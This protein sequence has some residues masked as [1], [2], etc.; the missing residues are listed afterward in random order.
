MA[1]AHH[2]YFCGVCGQVL[3]DV[4]VPISIGG[5]AGAPWH[6]DEWMTWLPGTTAMDIGGVKTSGFKGFTTT[7]GRGQPVHVDSLHTMRRVEK[8]SEQAYRNGEG[9]PMVFRRWAQDCS[10]KDQPTLSK[11]YYGGEAPTKAAA[12][13]FGS[14]AKR[15]SEAP[16][17]GYGPGVS[18]ANA[19]A[20]PLS[21]G[22]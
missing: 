6:C 21:G 11:S 5:R 20:L 4:L 9:Q 10:N 12:H 18:D 3:I 22:E 8:E 1:L 15:A 13:K 16:D 17:T 2:D 14:T 7:D 19:S